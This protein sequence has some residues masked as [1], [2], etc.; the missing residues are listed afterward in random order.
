M[1]LASNY[2]STP[3]QIVFTKNF[4]LLKSHYRKLMSP[5]LDFEIWRILFVSEGEAL[6]FDKM[7]FQIFL[8]ESL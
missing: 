5:I 3:Y 8:T 1:D 4:E 6:F 2:F 7:Y